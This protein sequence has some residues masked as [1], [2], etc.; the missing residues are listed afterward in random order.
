MPIHADCQATHDENVVEHGQPSAATRV[1]QAQPP[2]DQPTGSREGAPNEYRAFKPCNCVCFHCHARFWYEERLTVSTRRS[3]IVQ[4]LI[5]IL[6]QHNALVQLFRTARDKLQEVNIPEFKVRL[7]SVVG[8]A[9]HELPTAD[10]IGAIVFDSGPETEADFD[11]I[12]EAH[13]DTRS[14]K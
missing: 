5:D 12:V 8:S 14:S 11:I 9:Q 2:P 1:P 6:D 10:D 13:S 4:G 3:E 7:F